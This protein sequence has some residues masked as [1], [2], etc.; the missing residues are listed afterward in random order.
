VG[1]LERKRALVQ[2]HAEGAAEGV[3]WMKLMVLKRLEVSRMVDATN[4]DQLWLIKQAP[5]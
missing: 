2:R 3:H 4:L 5:L 1:Q